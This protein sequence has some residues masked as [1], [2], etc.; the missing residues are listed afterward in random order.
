MTFGLLSEGKM[1]RKVF[2]IDSH[3]SQ[4]T[5]QKFDEFLKK[6]KIQN[7]KL[8]ITKIIVNK[9]PGSYTGTRVGVTIG[10]ALSLAWK[11]PVKFLSADQFSSQMR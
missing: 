4:E 10:Q 3:K 8:K 7:L 5:L 1:H 11:V 6:T 9:G 2:K